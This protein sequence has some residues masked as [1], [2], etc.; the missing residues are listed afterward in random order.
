[1][2]FKKN[3]NVTDVRAQHVDIALA[4]LVSGT[5]LTVMDLPADSVIVG[6]ALTTLQAFNS[7]TSD[8]MAVGADATGNRYLNA[9]NIRAAN[10]HVALVPTGYAQSGPLT[11]TWTSGGGTPTTGKVRLVVQYVT[12]NTSTG[13]HG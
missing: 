10:A 1:M 9:G 8:V 3:F 11:V 5:A 12:L 7:D 4:D 13:T 2:S 6:G